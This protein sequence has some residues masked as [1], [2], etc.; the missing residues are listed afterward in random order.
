MNLSPVREAWMKKNDTN[1][2]IHE[3]A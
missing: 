3:S 2:I 1:R